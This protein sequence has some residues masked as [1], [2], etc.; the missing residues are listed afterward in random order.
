MKKVTLA[1]MAAM[2]LVGSV[3][4]DCTIKKAAYSAGYTYGKDRAMHSVGN[5]KF[6]LNIVSDGPCAA[7]TD[8]YSGFN[9]YK[10]L[11]SDQVHQLCMNGAVD[12][13]NKMNDYTRLDFDCSSLDLAKSV[14]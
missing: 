9:P 8:V 10:K 3:S 11:S 12:A 5:L 14:R 7:Y 13:L 1:A 6:D 2:V 4:A